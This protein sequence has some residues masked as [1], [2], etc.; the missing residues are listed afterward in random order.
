MAARLLDGRAIAKDIEDEVALRVAALRCGPPCLAVVLIGATEPA[1]AY[2]RGIEAAAGRCGV[3]VRALELAAGGPPGEAFEQ[4]ARLNRDPAVHGI[5]LKRPLPGQ[6]GDEEL[7]QALDP[8]KD[9]DGCHFQNLGRLVVWGARAGHVPCTPAGVLEILRR[10]GIPTRG[11]HAVIL[12]RSVTVGR[13]LA[14]LLLQKDAWADATVT[15]CHSST[16]DLAEHTRRADLLVVAAGRPALIT[17]D[18]VKPGA[19]VID[20]AG[21]G[22]IEG[23]E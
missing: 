12:G 5:L 17:A 15:L 20:S 11:V 3:A 21:L 13:P 22:V 23:Q 8:V 18:H 16:R 2:R 6:L 1:R 19:I 10:S 14:N 7:L 4:I 9:V